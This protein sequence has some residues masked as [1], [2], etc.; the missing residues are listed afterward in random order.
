F[1]MI[2][3]MS[4]IS[5]IGFGL[6]MSAAIP[7]AILFTSM[8]GLLIERTLIRQAKNSTTVTLVVITIGLSIFLKGLGLIIWGTYPKTL[9]PIIQMKPIQIFGAVLNPQSLFIF[10]VLVF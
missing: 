1:A 10:G 7:L 8:V 2:G 6:P 3:A 9:P 4:C 5:L